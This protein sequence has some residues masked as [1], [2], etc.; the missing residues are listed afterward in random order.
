VSQG[1]GQRKRASELHRGSL[2]TN[3]CCQYILF[4]LEREFIPLC[5]FLTQLQRVSRPN[6]RSSTHRTFSLPKSDCA[7]FVMDIALEQASLRTINLFAQS[8][9]LW[10]V[11][12][13]NPILWLN[14]HT[15]IT[16]HKPIGRGA[17]LC[18][19]QLIFACESSPVSTIFTQK[20]ENLSHLPSR[21]TSK[22]Q[23][24]L[25]LN[26]NPI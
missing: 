2:S 7:K 20:L 10:V 1:E 4:L 13:I 24:Q 14:S 3:L 16:L 26:I 6:D 11:N 18:T 5:Y 21:N 23:F 17:I 19:F 9:P 25:G 15:P 8:T 12:T 22:Q